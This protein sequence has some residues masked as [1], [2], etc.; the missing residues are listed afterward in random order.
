MQVRAIPTWKL[1]EILNSHHCTGINGADYGPIKEEL[2]NELWRRTES[3][4]HDSI[5]QHERAQLDYALI[6]EEDEV[7]RLVNEVNEAA[8][9]VIAGWDRVE[10]SVEDDELPPPVPYEARMSWLHTIAIPKSELPKRETVQAPARPAPAPRNA[11]E[12]LPRPPRA[13]LRAPPGLAY[14]PNYRFIL[15]KFDS[16]CHGCQSEI[17][18]GDLILWYKLTKRVFCSLCEEFDTANRERMAN[19]LPN[20]RG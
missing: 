10:T 19:G 4:G 17:E 20:I 9:K 16:H 14:A 3:V 6:L 5:K 15:A 2:Q 8:D 12:G 11:W 1:E 7:L 13:P 18:R